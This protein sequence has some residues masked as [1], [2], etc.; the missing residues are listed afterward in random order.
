[1][2]S[3]SKIFEKELFQAA[4]ELHIQIASIIQK[5]VEGLVAY[6]LQYILKTETV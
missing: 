2:G 5:P 6:H 1:V 4:A 3:L